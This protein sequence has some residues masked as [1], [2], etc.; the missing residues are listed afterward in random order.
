M[1]LNTQSK[2]VRNHIMKS[3]L[4]NGKS[5]RNLKFKEEEKKMVVVCPLQCCRVIH[6]ILNAHGALK[7]NKHVQYTYTVH[8]HLKGRE[9]MKRN[10]VVFHSM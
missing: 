9:K 3:S 2:N 7:I 10:I 8:T 5:I 4:S 1:T 6:N